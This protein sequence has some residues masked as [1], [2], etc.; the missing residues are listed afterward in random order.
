L[1]ASTSAGLVRDTAAEMAEVIEAMG[2]KRQ[3]WLPGFRIKVLDGNC[4]EA[5][6]HRL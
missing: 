1:E 4:I 5:T 2:A 6:E 3:P